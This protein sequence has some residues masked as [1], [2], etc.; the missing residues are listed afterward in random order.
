MRIT[1]LLVKQSRTIDTV[2]YRLVLTMIMNM[3]LGYDQPN[4]QVDTGFTSR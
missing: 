4:W 1:V 2:I 3:T